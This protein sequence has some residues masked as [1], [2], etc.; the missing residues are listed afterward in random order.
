MQAA[1]KSRFRDA[2]ERMSQSIGWLLIFEQYDDDNSGE[3]ELDVRFSIDVHCFATDLR[4]IC[5]W[6][7]SILTH[8]SSPKPC[9]RSAS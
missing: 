4:L 7:G 6:F 5:D 2:S 1:L 3:L 8:R 9:E